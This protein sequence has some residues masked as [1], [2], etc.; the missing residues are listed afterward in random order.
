MNYSGDVTPSKA[1]AALASD[2][3]A[4]LIDVRTQPEWAFVGVPELSSIGKRVGFISWQV[5]PQMNVD[6][7][8]AEKVAGLVGANKDTPLFFLCR[9]GNRSCAAAIALTEA[10]F[11]H[12][13]NIAHGFEGDRDKSG[14]RGGVNGWKVEQLPWV[15]Q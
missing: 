12:C 11:L 8:F 10:G 15:Q 4:Q 1:F 2:P 14:H 3:T 9:S 6:P 7:M 5:F 13:Y